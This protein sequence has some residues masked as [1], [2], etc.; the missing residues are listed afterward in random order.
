MKASP[1]E[2]DSFSATAART[3]SLGSMI[4]QDSNRLYHRNENVSTIFK[5]KMGSSQ[6]L[7]F[8]IVLHE[9]GFD[10]SCLVFS[11]S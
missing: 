8:A 3:E 2:T 9:V 10:S 6:L 1:E 5:L 11:A 7:S 4:M